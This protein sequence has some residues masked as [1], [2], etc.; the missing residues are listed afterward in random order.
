MEGADA[1]EGGG[2]R[3]F[4]LAGK[5]GGDVAGALPGR[6]WAIRWKQG[7]LREGVARGVSYSLTPGGTRSVCV[8]VDQA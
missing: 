7:A 6:D 1:P 3:H 8:F 4:L 2:G 5:D